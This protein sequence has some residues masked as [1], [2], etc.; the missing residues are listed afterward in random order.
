MN[1]RPQNHPGCELAT[2]DQRPAPGQAEAAVDDMRLT[3]GARTVGRDDVRIVMDGVRRLRGELSSGPMRIAVPHAPRYR[4][5][6]FRQLLEY[7]DAVHWRQVEPAIGRR[8]ENAKKSSSGEVAR[9][10]FRQPSGCFDSIAL[11]DNARPEVASS[12]KKL[13]AVRRIVR[14]HR[15]RSPRSDHGAHSQFVDRGDPEYLILAP[16]RGL[17]ENAADTG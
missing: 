5:V 6:R 14:H 8:Q 10:L 2:A 17:V 16:A 1:D 3:R 13:G 7:R 15:W 11:R 12:C 4:R 9:E